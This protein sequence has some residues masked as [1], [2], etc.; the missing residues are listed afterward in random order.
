MRVGEAIK[1][2]NM[3]CYVWKSTSSNSWE[4]FNVWEDLDSSLMY[5]NCVLFD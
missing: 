4:Y 1:A 2:L 3:E 5:A